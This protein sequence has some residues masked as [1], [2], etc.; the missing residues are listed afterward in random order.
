MLKELYEGSQALFAGLGQSSNGM[1]HVHDYLVIRIGFGGNVLRHAPELG[2]SI[3]ETIR[4][5]RQLPG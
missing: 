4:V 2:D 1:G 3:C 5:N